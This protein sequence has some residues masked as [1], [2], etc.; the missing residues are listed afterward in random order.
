MTLY[1]LKILKYT[2]KIAFIAV[3]FSLI[4][5]LKTSEGFS[6]ISSKTNLEIFESDIS[7][8]IEKV[9][10]YPEINRDQKFIFLIISEN[11]NKNRNKEE[12]KFFEQVLR[13][14]ADKNNISYS[15]AKDEKMEAPDSVYNRL[16]IKINRLNTYYPGFI[17]NGFLGEKTMKRRI[18]SEMEIIIKNNSS[19]ILAEENL[20]SNFFDEIFFE[21][22]S[23]YESPEYK[24]TQSTPPGLSL[25]ESIIF[26]AAVITAS[27]VAALLFFSIRSK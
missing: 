18:I 10:L 14:T 26:P 11:R 15:F 27:A 9:I 17:K 5:V 1:L 20:N 19:S 25:V 24:F 13:K 16:T 8:G 2:N 6:Q 12:K 23:R 3:L 4:A 7:S 22:Y 21:D